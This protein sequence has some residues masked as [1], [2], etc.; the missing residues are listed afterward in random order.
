MNRTYQLTEINAN[1]VIASKSV[2]ASHYLGKQ[3]YRQLMCQSGAE[4][5]D[6]KN[7]D[8]QL[9]CMETSPIIEE[10]GDGGEKSYHLLAN[11]YV[12][13]QEVYQKV[14]TEIDTMLAYAA[15]ELL[16]KYLFFMEMYDR[17]GY[18]YDILKQ[19][20]SECGDVVDE[21]LFRHLMLSFLIPAELAK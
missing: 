21:E 7:F 13:Y 15:P 4:E 18:D 2:M 14:L 17:R 11:V 16:Y 5:E 3:R 6:N 10:S 1:D 20:Y 9:P 12:R 19:R 8:I